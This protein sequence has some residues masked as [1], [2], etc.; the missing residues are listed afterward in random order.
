MVAPV[1]NE[2]YALPIKLINSK[3]LLQFMMKKIEKNYKKRRLFS[4]GKRR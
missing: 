1:W 2:C 4:I 3:T